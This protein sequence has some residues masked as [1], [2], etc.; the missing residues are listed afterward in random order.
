MH[1]V[2][3]S[4]VDVRTIALARCPLATREDLEP[5]EQEI[6]REMKDYWLYGVE[7]V[8]GC[9][10]TELF[11]A[12]QAVAREFARSAPI[13]RRCQVHEGKTGWAKR[14]T[15]SGDRVCAHCGNSPAR[16]TEPGPDGIRI[17]AK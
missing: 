12:T 4:D 17:V 6:F 11:L 8:P 7:A 14:R 2:F 13:D 10:Q 1:K 5:L 15:S 9:E 16:S 3:G